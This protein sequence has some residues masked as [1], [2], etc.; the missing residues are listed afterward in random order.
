MLQMPMRWSTLGIR[1]RRE[2]G[3]KLMEFM[4]SIG[5]IKYRNGV[6][7]NKVGVNVVR[8][9]ECLKI[10]SCVATHMADDSG[11]PYQPVG[12]ETE[13]CK[14]LE[15]LAQGVHPEEYSRE[16][17]IAKIEQQVCKLCVCL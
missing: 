12:V 7:G 11:T 8:A 17:F 4:A 3:C 6:G 2:N 9:Q 13:I 5:A 14:A 1:Q 10:F 16:G 15:W